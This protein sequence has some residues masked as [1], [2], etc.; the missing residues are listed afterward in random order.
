M[1]V[2][3]VAVRVVVHPR[4]V[5]VLGASRVTD[6]R[7]GVHW[8]F[9]VALAEGQGVRR[10][11]RPLAVPRAIDIELERLVG[12]ARRREAEVTGVVAVRIEDGPATARGVHGYE[13]IVLTV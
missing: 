1:I 8:T 5:E 6:V 9:R 11:D 7:I 10:I 3:Q 4:I 2:G 12:T 13:G